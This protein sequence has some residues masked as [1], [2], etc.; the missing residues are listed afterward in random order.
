[1]PIMVWLMHLFCLVYGYQNKLEYN[2]NNLSFSHCL[3]VNDFE[4]SPLQ[5]S[6]E[7]SCPFNP[8]LAGIWIMS[9][10]QVT[11]VNMDNIL[12]NIF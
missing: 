1:M 8:Y 9:G 5:A 2:D 10:Q 4:A 12:P 6:V 3:G 11:V 7:G